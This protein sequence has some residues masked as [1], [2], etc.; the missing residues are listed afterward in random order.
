MF[1]LWFRVQRKYRDRKY[2]NWL[3]FS[4]FFFS[5]RCLWII[6]NTT[7]F[8]TDQ[9]LI[10]RFL[11]Y[12]LLRVL[13]ALCC[14][15]QC[16]CLLAVVL[17]RDPTHIQLLLNAPGSSSKRDSQKPLPLMGT[18]PSPVYWC[19][20]WFMPFCSFQC[21]RGGAYR[22]VI[23]SLVG[24]FNTSDLYSYPEPSV[25]SQL[26][27]SVRYIKTKNSYNLIE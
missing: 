22:R 2:G 7:I 16:N 9:P 21:H 20:Q 8:T 24:V 4:R 5:H 10:R 11:W 1:A 25:L 17:S 18:L 15:P 19:T 27:Y 13:G 14:L 12:L 3:I 6:A 23:L 26:E